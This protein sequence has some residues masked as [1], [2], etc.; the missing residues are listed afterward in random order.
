MRVRL[1]SQYE[2]VVWATPTD[3]E[4]QSKLPLFS[5]AARIASLIASVMTILTSETICWFVAGP[6]GERSTND[7]ILRRI[8]K[9]TSITIH[10]K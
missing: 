6:N 10:H 3:R 7:Y 9:K 8:A 1:L 5:M 2:T 4:K